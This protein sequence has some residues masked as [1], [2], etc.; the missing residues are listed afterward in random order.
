LTVV[1]ELGAPK[2]RFIDRDKE[3]DVLS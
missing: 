3:N 2:H 1:H